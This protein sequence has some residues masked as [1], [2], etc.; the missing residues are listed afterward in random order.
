MNPCQMYTFPSFF[1]TLKSN[2]ARPGEIMNTVG[3]LTWVF[4]SCFLCCEYGECVT[5]QFNLFDEELRCC[6]WYLFPIEMQRSMLIILTGNQQLEVIQ[7][8]ANTVCTRDAFKMVK[9]MNLA[10]RFK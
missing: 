1:L 8:Y 7:G 4:S 9:V 3:G 6:G 5:H 2:D 10:I